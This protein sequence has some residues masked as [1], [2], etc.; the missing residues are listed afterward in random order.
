MDAHSFQDDDYFQEDMLLHGEQQVAGPSAGDILARV[1]LRVAFGSEKLL[2]LE[3]LVMEIARRAADI[4]PLMREPQSISA[5][6]V[7]KAFEFDALYGIVDSE[8]NELEKLVASIQMDIA[9][10][11][12]KVSEEEPWSRLTDKL[13]TAT[14]S[15][16]RMQELISTIRR[17]SATFEKTIQPSHDNQ[18]T[19]EVMGYENGHMST[20]T[21]MQAE[22]QRNVLQMLQQSIASELDLQQKIFDSQS[23]VE[24][25]K[26]KLHYA[27]QESYFLEEFIGALYK[28]MFA[29]ENASQ[30]FLGASKE[31]IGTIDTIQ[32]SLTASVCREGDLKSKLEESLMKL[33]VNQST[34]ET[35]P[36]DSDKNASQEAVQMQVLSPPEFLTLR[37]KVQQ[38]EEW[39]RDS[40]SHPQWSLLSRGETE[41]EQNT[42]QAEINPFGNIISDLKLAITNA[43]SRTQNAEARCTQLTQ[44]NVQLSGQLD[45]LKSQGSDRAGL[46]ETKLKESDTQLEHARASVDAIVEQ[47]GMLRSSMSD[48]E[49]MIE[50]LKEKYLKAETRAENAESKCS[51]LT[52]TNLELSEELSFLRGRVESLENSLHQ[53]NQLKMCTAKDIGSKTK[54]ITDLVAKLALERERLHL[55]IVTLTKKNRI[56]AKKCKENDSGATSL[57]EEVTAT[58]GELRPLKVMEEASLNCSTT[59]H[60]VAPTGSTP[61]EEVEAEEVTTLEDE[62]GARRT[63]ETVRPIESLQ[64]NW[65]HISVALLV[66]LAA[67]LVYQ[68]YQSDDRVEQLLRKFLG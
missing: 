52:D 58:E 32:F 18:G 23:S 63:L 13:H 57:S 22:D 56:L 28:R 65:K 46:L 36:G 44:T 4:E 8:T 24:D 55:Q 53:A 43:E 9:S 51:L 17:E 26:M 38:L 45:S 15:L 20:H 54:T 42:M 49:H 21:T 7:D 6:S 3:M 12:G 29:A 11:E 61:Q 40:G 59:Q 47:Q 1:D 50:D 27:E 5:E 30:L 10:A 2:N 60:K 35:V 16:K 62:S 64:L 48:M 39:L 37:N 67:V 19:G 66:L 68:L 34:R 25:L 31:L 14:D 41:E 33:N